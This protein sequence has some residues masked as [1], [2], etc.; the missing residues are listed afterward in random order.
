MKIVLE[1]DRPLTSKQIERIHERAPRLIDDDWLGVWWHV[2]DVHDVAD[3]NGLILDKNAAQRVLRAL[4]V[5][6]DWNAGITWD[7]VRHYVEI[8]QIK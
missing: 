8:Y 2:G 4:E 5:N 6:L 3:D 1:F 7:T